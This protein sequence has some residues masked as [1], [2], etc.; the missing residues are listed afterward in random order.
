VPAKSN[1]VCFQDFDTRDY[2][3]EVQGRFI[4][5]TKEQFDDGKWQEIVRRK[6]Q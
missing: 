2:K 3:L 1:V 4:T 5:I 6:F